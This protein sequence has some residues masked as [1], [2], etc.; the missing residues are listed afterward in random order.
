MKLNTDISKSIY[1][2]KKK[3]ILIWMYNGKILPV[4]SKVQKTKMQFLAGSLTLIMFKIQ[5]RKKKERRKIMEKAHILVYA[6]HLTPV[7]QLKV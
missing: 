7:N 2:K 3:I 5:N 1:R 6:Y 4:P